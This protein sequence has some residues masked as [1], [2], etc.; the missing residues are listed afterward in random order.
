MRP[1]QRPAAECQ[2]LRLPKTADSEGSLRR[3]RPIA[4]QQSIRRCQTFLNGAICGAHAW[5]SCLFKSIP[6]KQ[7]QTGVQLI[8]IE[9]A[10]VT[11]Q[12]LIP[13]ALLDLTSDQLA[14][15]LVD[16][17]WSPAQQSPF[18]KGY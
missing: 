17:Q 12:S 3:F 18:L 1:F 6:R 10:D 14:I 8:A 2:V 4:I 15:V 7:K 16:I 11:L 5:R 9:Q 13:T